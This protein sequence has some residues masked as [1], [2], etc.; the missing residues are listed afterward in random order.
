MTILLYDY[1]Y[2]K[3]WLFELQVKQP[4]NLGHFY[5][6]VWLQDITINNVL[7]S[8]GQSST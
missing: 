7:N 6:F 8:F 4:K 3:N 5:S 1:F 2:P